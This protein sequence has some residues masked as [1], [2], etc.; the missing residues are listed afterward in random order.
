VRRFRALS[1][2]ELLIMMARPPS[3]WPI[4]TAQVIL[5]FV[6]SRLSFSTKSSDPPKQAA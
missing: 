4:V 2:V 6:T 1:F 3:H 5:A